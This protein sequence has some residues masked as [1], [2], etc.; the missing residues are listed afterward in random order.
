VR[1]RARREGT[2]E[3]EG[4]AA[5]EAGPRAASPRRP[6]PL[7]F[8]LL[9]PF[10]GAVSPRVTT[11]AHHAISAARTSESGTGTRGS[12]SPAAHTR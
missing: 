2:D 3:D 9:V 1:R 4:R 7:A 10:L 5:G 6:S 8:S 12:I 11:Y